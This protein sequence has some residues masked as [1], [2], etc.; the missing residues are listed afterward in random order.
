M[1]S[2]DTIAT[3]RRGQEKE[4]EREK[5]ATPIQFARNSE[6]E[7]SFGNHGSFCGTRLWP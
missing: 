4:I 2:S 6:A 1:Q 3:P 7:A 5:D